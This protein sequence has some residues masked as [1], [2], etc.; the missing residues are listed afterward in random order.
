MMPNAS[1]SAPRVA[2]LHVHTTAS[3]GHW[4]SGDVVRYLAEIGFSAVGIADHDEISGIPEAIEAGRACGVEIVPAV[5]LSTAVGEK[6]VH[7]LGYHIDCEARELREVLEACRTHR[8]HRM[9]TMVE[10]LAKV[11]VPIDIGRVHELAGEGAIGRPHLAQAMIE[12]GHV[13]TI[14][15]AFVRYLSPGLPGYAPKWKM[16]PAEACA[17]V[18]RIGGVPVLAHPMLLRD[19]ALVAQIIRDGALGLEA[20]YAYVSPEVTTRYVRMAETAGLVVTGGSDCHQ[21]DGS[22]AMGRVRLPHA[23]VEALRERWRALQAGR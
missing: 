14:D 1:Q 19:D 7:I 9:D 4:S 13:R 2:D 8:R 10:R 12:A 15:E 21:I 17:F 5:E 20:Y 22:I 18:R 16:T 23:R 11:G 3:D 6:E